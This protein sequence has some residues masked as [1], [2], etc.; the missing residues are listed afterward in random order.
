MEAYSTTADLK[1]YHPHS[2]EETHDEEGFA[3]EEA[4][5]L[6]V[7]KHETHDDMQT[8][9]GRGRRNRVAYR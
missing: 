1:Q 6:I 8:E 3:E 7:P 5:S 9:R 2:I 4:E